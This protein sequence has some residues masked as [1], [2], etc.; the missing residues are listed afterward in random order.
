M[1]STSLVISTTLVFLMLYMQP[2]NMLTKNSFTVGLNVDAAL[3]SP[4]LESKLL[5]IGAKVKAA[6]WCSPT[7]TTSSSRAK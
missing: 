2:H 7:L 6:L 5:R 1:R 4:C 3:I